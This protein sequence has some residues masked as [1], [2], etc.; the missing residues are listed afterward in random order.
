MTKEFILTFSLCIQSVDVM[1]LLGLS[2]WTK[3]SSSY[4]LM[5]AN[6]TSEWSKWQRSQAAQCNQCNGTELF[7][8]T[9]RPANLGH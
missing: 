3:A 9:Q 2:H 7:K 8:S 1:D 6:I 5:L 4:S